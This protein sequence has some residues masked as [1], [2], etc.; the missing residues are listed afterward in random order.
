MFD[1]NWI[2]LP[3]SC[4]ILIESKLKSITLLHFSIYYYKNMIKGENKDS[5]VRVN[6][7]SKHIEQIDFE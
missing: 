1:L 6:D 5:Q 7:I 4:C 2:E 3:Y